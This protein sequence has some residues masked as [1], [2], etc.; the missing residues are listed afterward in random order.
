[1][2]RSSITHISAVFFIGLLGASFQEKVPGGF[3]KR[4]EEIV[5]IVRD[6]FFDAA[7]ANS[8]AATHANY[9]AK[10]TT[11]REF[12]EMT[13][14]ALND[15]Q[16]SHTAYYTP[17]DRQYHDLLSIFRPYLKRKEVVVDSI[18][19]DFTSEGFVR[20]V[21]AGGPGE[22]AGLHRGDRVLK[23]DGKA[24]E[25]FVSFRGKSGA[26]VTL[27]VQRHKTG[28]PRE[29]VVTPRRTDINDEWVEAQKLGT[30]LFER[31]GKT[32]AY[33]PFFTAAGMVYQDILLEAISDQF[34]KADALIIDFRNGWGG[35]NPTFLNLFDKSAPALTQIPRD[36]PRTLY[37]P[38]WRK[39][40]YILINGGTKSGKE[41]VAYAIRK[42]KIGTLVGEGTGGAVLA[43]TPFLV[44]GGLMYLAVSD[45]LVDGERLEGKGVAPDREVHDTLEYADGADPQLELALELAAH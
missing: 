31:Q 27:T 30:K 20:V 8:W 45:I 18:G 19:V 11:E 32:I 24:F 3:E 7:K 43:G 41:A 21:F 10:A 38:H 1:M 2:K 22:K 34:V 23:A 9:A 5:T 40:L 4:G 44:D 14:A 13:R 28:S 39:P 29:I 16:S 6:R 36:G 26:E 42:H 12:V 15:L 17:D 25:P 35:A 37:D 33:M